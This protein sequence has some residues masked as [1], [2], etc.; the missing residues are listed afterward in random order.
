M[1]FDVRTCY[2]GLMINDPEV[3][4][5]SSY[6]QFFDVPKPILFRK[7]AINCLFNGNRFKYPRLPFEESQIEEM[8]EEEI[9]EKVRRQLYVEFAQHE[10]LPYRVAYEH[11][12]FHILMNSKQQLE[13]KKNDIFRKYFLKIGK[14]SLTI[15]DDKNQI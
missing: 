6:N 8:P 15:T 2:Y 11:E 5:D 1:R 4:L 3:V 14:G 9:E 12:N 13:L 7:S 10:N